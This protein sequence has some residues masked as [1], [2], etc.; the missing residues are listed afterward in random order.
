MTTESLLA[1]LMGHGIQFWLDA[2]KLRFRVP[3]GCL[4]PE[5]QTLFKKNK[6]EIIRIIS[7]HDGK[8]CILHPLSFNQ[9]SLWFLHQLTPKSASYNVAL[10]CRIHSKLNHSAIQYAFNC[11]VNRH[12]TLRST[13][14][15][16][17]DDESVSCQFIH[18]SIETPLTF[19]DASSYSE[20]ELRQKLHES[21]AQPFDLAQ[22]PVIRGH[23][24]SQKED[25]HVF[26]ITVHHVSCDAFSLGNAMEEFADRY[27]TFTSSESPF[28]AEPDISYLGFIKS[29]YEILNSSSGD[30]LWHY[31]QN[32]LPPNLPILDLPGD[33]PR[34]SIRSSNGETYRFTLQK[35]THQQLTKSVKDKGTTLY[36]WLLAVFNVMLYRLSGQNEFIVGAPVSGRS[37]TEY[38]SSFGYFVNIVPL[39]TNISLNTSF[40]DYLKIVQK[41][42]LGALEHQDM[43]FPVLVEKLSPTRE[44]GMTPVFQ[45]MFNFLHRSLLNSAAPFLY[46]SADNSPVDFGGLQIEAYPLNQ[47]EGQFDLTL[48]IIDNG[49]QLFCVLKYSTDLFEK[50]TIEHFTDYYLT[51]LSASISDA[52]KTINELPLPDETKIAVTP[53][54][55]ANFDVILASSFTI[56]PIEPGLKYWFKKIDIPANIRFAPYNQIFQQLLDPSSL[57]SRNLNGLNI[58]VL[59]LEDWRGDQPQDVAL[60][61][62][63]IQRNS[64]ELLQGIKAAAEHSPGTSFL[65]IMCPVSPATQNDTNAHTFFKSVEA[66]LCDKLHSLPGIYAVSSRELMETY[67]VADYYQV[68]GET[69]GH[70]PYTEPFY[71]ALSTLISRRL[72]SFKSSPPKVIAVDCDNTLWSGVVGEDGPLGVSITSAH[73]ALQQLLIDQKNKGRLVCLCSKNEEKDVQDV[74]ETHPDMVLKWKD[75][76]F[77]RINWNPKSVNLRSLSS[78]INVGIDS[79]IFIDDN[80]VECAEVKSNCPSIFTIHIPEDNTVWPEFLKHI[81][82][83][84][85]LKSTSEDKKRAKMYENAVK[86]ESF[87]SESHSFEDFLQGLNLQITIKPLITE[88]IPRAAQLTQRT[89][90][91]NFTTIRK[92]EKEIQA[93]LNDASPTCFTTHVRDRFGDYGLVGVIIFNQQGN[94][95][96]TDTFLLSCRTMGKGVE[97]AMVSDLGRIALERNIDTIEFYSTTSDRNLPAR[98]FLNTFDKEC[99]TEQ[100]D[101]ITRVLLTPEQSQSCTFQPEIFKADEPSETKAKQSSAP[102]QSALIKQYESLV[103]EIAILSASPDSVLKEIKDES[104]TLKTIRITDTTAPSSETE[105]KIVAI[106]KNTLNIDTLGINSNFFDLGGKSLLIP[107]IVIALK[108]QHDIDI[109]IV[110]MFQYPTI[111]LLA[112]HIDSDDTS[113]VLMK[114]KSSAEKQKAA[115]AASGKK[116]PFARLRSQRKT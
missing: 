98:M 67:Q 19:S 20:A 53:A 105:Q 65:V 115:L 100:N 62:E 45:V 83:F 87:L 52:E 68:L 104:T 99:I 26:L 39:L 1:P 113:S 86:R 22:G 69:V 78:Q 60:Y 95:I 24:F 59:R 110:D 41:D 14:N 30:K 112:S 37:K 70:I 108:N 40:K 111:A 107:Q 73:K 74:F 109:S 58:V 50:E 25:R 3:K 101:E 7:L 102:V 114:A 16:L 49:A 79:F 28:S 4:T 116:N 21:Y 93:L 84:D 94:R 85:Q 80:P 51:L 38:E 29:Q 23:V 54:K 44:S 81:W 77:S 35:E 15:I 96:I 82:V 63:S 88:N 31:W 75:V 64:E 103:S 17:S 32:T 89:N 57:F 47:Q 27:K 8:S 48:E 2:D 11:I 36:S 46:P 18:K 34:P 10:A 42:L 13:Y 43:P 9:Q 6:A 91:F 97:H 76:S 106:W 71:V 55:A 33:H 5:L 66:D 92:T 90:Q 61:Q 72:F 56:E 12:S